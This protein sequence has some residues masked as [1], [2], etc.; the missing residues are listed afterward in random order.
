M[1]CAARPRHAP[2]VGPS[3]AVARRRGDP[4]RPHHQRRAHPQLAGLAD[5]AALRPQVP[6][7]LDAADGRARRLAGHPPGRSRRAV[8]NALRAE[9]P[10][11]GVRPPPRE[12]AVPPPR[13]ERRRRRGGPQ[14]A[15]P[16]RADDRLRPPLRHVQAGRPDPDATS[17]AWP[18]CSTTRS[19]R[20]RSSS[21]ARPTR[22]TSRASS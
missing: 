8:G 10:A 12:P 2:H 14:H 15:R 9:E 1:S 5:A 19:G 4:H 7:R 22:P 20:C 3:L 17:T 18:T 16:Q 13:R 6:G 21:P 11:A